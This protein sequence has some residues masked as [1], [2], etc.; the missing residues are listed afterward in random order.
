[1]SLKSFSYHWVENLKKIHVLKATLNEPFLPSGRRKAS[2]RGARQ[3]RCSA[4]KGQ[5]PVQGH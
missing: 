4:Q 1:M 3:P 5:R 2:P